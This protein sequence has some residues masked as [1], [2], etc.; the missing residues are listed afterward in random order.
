MK[1]FKSKLFYTI[2]LI[3]FTILMI[4]TI[5]LRFARPSRSGSSGRGNMPPGFSSSDSSGFPGG[6]SGNF[7]G[8]FGGDFDPENFDPANI[9]E[10]FDPSNFGNGDFDPSNFQNGDFDPSNFHDKRRGIRAT[11]S[12]QTKQK[13]NLRLPQQ[14]SSLTY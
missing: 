11:Q 6:G 4:A 10:G 2:V 5:V 12:Q 9:P 8:G 1:V 7:P 3:V 13:A 14:K